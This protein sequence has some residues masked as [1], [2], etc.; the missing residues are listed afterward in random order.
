MAALLG[1]VIGAVLTG[2]LT[3][4]QYVWSS[5]AQVRA[6]RSN[7]RLA[8]VRELMRYRLDQARL[9]G[10]LNE[11]PLVF[12]DDRDVLRLYRSVLDAVDDVART[13]ALTDLV[14]RLALLV[15]LPAEVSMS[16]IQRGF[17]YK[18]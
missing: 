14:N 9:I 18:G 1:A 12:G 4:V 15:G 3:Y 8:L 7:Q 5:R 11:L 10:P 17:T 13:R 16:D 2:V 6:E